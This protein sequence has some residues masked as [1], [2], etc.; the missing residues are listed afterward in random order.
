MSGAVFFTCSA[1]KSLDDTI[2]AIATARGSAGIAVIR[3]SGARAIQIAD[4]IFVGKIRLRE[5]VSQRAY[6][7]KLISPD[8]EGIEKSRSSAFQDEVLITLFRAP[9][10][11]TREDVVEISCHGGEFL[12]QKILELLLKRGCRLADPGE[13]TQRAF[14]NGRLDL[15][16]AEAVSD[17]IRAKTDL[18]LKAALSQFEGIF[19][20]R[21]RGLRQQLIDIC[22]LLELELDFAEEDVQFADREEVKTRLLNVLA[23]VE[24][25]LD[26]YRRGKILREGVKLAIVGKPNVGKSSLLNALLREERAIVTEIPGT[27]RDVLEEQLSL[28]GLLFRVVDTAGLRETSDI[29]E[30]EGVTRTLKQISS[31]DIALLVFDGSEELS[32]QDN[33]LVQQVFSLRGPAQSQN[34]IIAVI[35]KIDL[36]TRIDKNKLKDDIGDLQVVE[37]SAK[38]MIGLDSLEKALVDLT[39]GKES[40]ILNGDPVVTNL[41]QK[42]ALDRALLALNLA[43]KSLKDQISSEFVAIDLR[44]ALDCLG[45]I[46]G[47]VTTEDILGNIFSKFCIGK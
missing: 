4:E 3:I 14:L 33:Q 38:E 28:G 9:K 42:D 8:P 27:T 46:I 39:V 45:E 17:I 24:A 40:L 44:S 22:S 16:Q 19:A 41:R 15:T 21:I 35:N 25:F 23:E 31:A 7:G 26:S 34:N 6:L 20:K 10:S 43:L 13:F 1:M 18:S 5:G 36:H 2:A 47:E 32:V 29:V 11:Y 30:R 37:I 12:S